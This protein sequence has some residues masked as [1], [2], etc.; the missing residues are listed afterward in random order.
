MPK[1]PHYKQLDSMD[2]A[3]PACAWWLNIMAKV[4]VCSICVAILILPAKGYPCW[5][6]ARQQKTSDSVPKVTVNM[7]RIE[8]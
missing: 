8:G 6:L 3:P 1:F 7:G 5:E 2:A 4:T